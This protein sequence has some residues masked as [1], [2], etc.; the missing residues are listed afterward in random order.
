MSDAPAVS[1]ILP[2]HNRAALLRQAVAS[3]QAQTF[4]DWELIIVDDGSTDDTAAVAEALS[5]Q[6]ARI[7]VVRQPNRGGAAAR[8]AGIRQARG[9][10]VAFQDD[11]DLWHAEKLSRQ[12]AVLSSGHPEYGWLYGFM[13]VENLVTGARS[14]HGRVV[15]TYRE[16]FSGYFIGTP[17]VLIRQS[18]FSRVGLFTED[19]ALWGAEDLELFLRLA[20]H[21]RFGCLPEPVITRYIR[22]EQASLERQAQ[23]LEAT[24]RVYQG[25]DLS[26]QTDVRRIDKIRKVADLHYH[27]ACFYREHGAYRQAAGH[28]ARAV[29]TY[30]PIGLYLSTGSLT[31]RQRIR[32]ALAPAVQGAACLLKASKNGFVI[33]PNT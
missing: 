10:F 8:N 12:C 31:V 30:P 9:T 13:E 7:R 24:V 2:T 23:Y 29:L 33:R 4:R 5:A 28:F 11:D 1:V 19:H 26:G 6:D 21:Y 15:T 27:I 3:V 25:L 17:T 18:C 22:D 16:L 14:T 20:T 32:S